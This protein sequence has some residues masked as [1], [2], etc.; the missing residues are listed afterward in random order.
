MLRL[1]WASDPVSFCQK[2]FYTSTTLAA[3]Q[4]TAGTWF[5]AGWP[6]LPSWQW[7]YRLGI[8]HLFTILCLRCWPWAGERP[9]WQG[10]HCIL[11]LSVGVAVTDSSKGYCVHMGHLPF[12]ATS[13]WTEVGAEKLHSLLTGCACPRYEEPPQPCKLLN[14]AAANNDVWFP[15]QTSG[16]PVPISISRSFH[17]PYPTHVITE[18][19][20]SSKIL[21][22]TFIHQYSGRDPSKG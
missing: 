16:Q 18:C 20:S 2:I 17:F 5:C 11:M 3:Q 4:G 7:E 12:A 22:T 19:L 6:F 10:W 13:H 8:S 1:P 9:W 21:I 14:S 15:W